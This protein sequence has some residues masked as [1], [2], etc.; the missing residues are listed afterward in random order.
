MWCVPPFILMEAIV[1]INGVEI[2]TQQL[3]GL[4]KLVERGWKLNYNSI[5]KLP[6]DTCIMIEVTGNNTGIK[7]TMGIEADGYTHS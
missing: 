3:Q 4:I 1:E 6:A 5:H 7:M 2:T